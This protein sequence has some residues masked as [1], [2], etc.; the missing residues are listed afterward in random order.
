[1]KARNLL[2]GG[3]RNKVLL[4]AALLGTAA[5]IAGLGSFASFTS[6]TSA[7][8]AHTSGTVTLGL[9]AAGGVDNRLTVGT[10]NLAAGDTIERAVKLTNSGTLDLSTATLTTTATT[11]SLLD[12]DATNGLQMQVDKCSAAWTE[13]AAP[14]TYTCS[15]TTTAVVA[16]RAVIGS[17]LALGSLASLTV[18]GSDYLRVKL[19]LPAAAPNTL[20][21][22]ASTLQYRF[23]ATQRAATSK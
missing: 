3:A 1:M 22:L 15:G 5:S 16:A 8:Q 9:G 19:T 2:L 7:S 18:G 17:N 11:S 4:T 13:S 20:Q 14:Y 21:G 10:A 23:D 12:T 6:T